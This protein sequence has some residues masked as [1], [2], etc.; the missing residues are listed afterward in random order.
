MHKMIR[1]GHTKQK[2]ETIDLNSIFN[3]LFKLL[4]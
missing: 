2:G 1:I 3:V 4:S